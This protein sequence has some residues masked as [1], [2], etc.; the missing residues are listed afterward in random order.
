MFGEPKERTPEDT[1]ARVSLY[2]NSHRQ[3][4]EQA[5]PESSYGRGRGYASRRT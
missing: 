5:A 4:P 3:G 2:K 1:A